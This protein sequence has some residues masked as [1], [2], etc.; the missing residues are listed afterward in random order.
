MGAGQ[1]SLQRP[2]ASA[3]ALGAQAIVRVSLDYEVVGMDKR[4]LLKVSAVGTAV[5]LVSG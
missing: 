1:C 3:D 4:T 5:T 2:A